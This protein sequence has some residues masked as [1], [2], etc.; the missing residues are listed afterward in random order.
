MPD[1]RTRFRKLTCLSPTGC[2]E[3]SVGNDITGGARVTFR[4]VAE[5]AI[6]DGGDNVHDVIGD[7]KLRGEDKLRGDDDVKRGA[8]GGQVRGEEAFAG[9]GVTLRE[10]AATCGI[11]TEAFSTVD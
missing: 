7:D 11:G 6:M 1:A 9:G 10:A 4:V 8:G 5:V 2:G 3:P